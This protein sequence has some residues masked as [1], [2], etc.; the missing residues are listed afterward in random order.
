MKESDDDQLLGNSSSRTE[1][2]EKDWEMV[3]NNLVIGE[4][5][6]EEETDPYTCHGRSSDQLNLKRHIKVK[7]NTE[8]PTSENPYSCTTCDYSCSQLGVFRRHIRKHTSFKQAVISK[9]FICEVCDF[10]CSHVKRLE[11]HMKMHL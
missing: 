10:V 5:E 6:K 8:N 4:M 11:S 9:P 7:T 1:E 3:M 2:K